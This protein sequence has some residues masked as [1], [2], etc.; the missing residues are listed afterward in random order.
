MAYLVEKL[1]WPRPKG[2]GHGH[3]IS[4]FRSSRGFCDEGA[5][6]NVNAI[7]CSHGNNRGTYIASRR[8][9]FRPRHPVD[10]WRRLLLDAK[11]N[12]PG[13][14]EK[15]NETTFDVIRTGERTEPLGR[16]N[17]R[18]SVEHRC[19]VSLFQNYHRQSA[20]AASIG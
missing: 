1:G 16:T 11:L 13:R 14:L 7:K 9:T 17:H 19:Y 2:Y 6:T 4:R 12:R 5:M 3:G 20:T 10:P 15:R 8:E 18:S